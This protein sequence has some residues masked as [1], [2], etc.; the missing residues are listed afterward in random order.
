MIYS[1]GE[2]RYLKDLDW[3]NIV[4]TIRELKTL[5]RIVLN[6]HQIQLLA[7]ERDSVLPSSK[8]NELRES[9]SLQRQVTFEY[10]KTIKHDEYSLKVKKFIDEL[11]MNSLTELDSKLINEVTL[12]DEDK[13]SDKIKQVQQNW[14]LP[15]AKLK[16]REILK[17]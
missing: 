13:T 16:R 2:D 9:I 12:E 15:S 11:E 3:V 4:K 17:E 7:F 10:D 6:Q 14:I 1:E 8:A 5:S